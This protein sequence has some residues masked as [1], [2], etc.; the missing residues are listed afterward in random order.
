M[1]GSLAAVRCSFPSQRKSSNALYVSHVDFYV[2]QWIDPRV[3][4][5]GTWVVFLLSLALQGH[6][7]LSRLR[8]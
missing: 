8:V 4:C 7:W 6:R 1:E 3:N 2:T 5:S